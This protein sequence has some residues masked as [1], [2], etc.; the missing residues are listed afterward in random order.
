MNNAPNGRPWWKLHSN[1][2]GVLG[3]VLLLLAWLSWPSYQLVGADPLWGWPLVF[4]YASPPASFDLGNF[5]I[6]VLFAA[7][8]L[9]GTVF[10]SERRMRLQGVSPF[11]LRKLL[12]VMATLAMYLAVNRASAYS[13]F[14][15]AVFVIQGICSLVFWLLILASWC[16]IFDAISHASNRAQHSPSER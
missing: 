2:W 13:A 3:F 4:L 15:E 16:A 1:S 11:T 8:V 14:V 12:A 6:D 5:V 7:F 9:I 10:A